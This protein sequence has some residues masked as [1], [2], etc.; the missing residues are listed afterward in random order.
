MQRSTTRYNAPSRV[1]RL[2]KPCHS[3]SAAEGP[4]PTSVH[5][6]QQIISSAI[7]GDI[8]LEQAAKAVASYAS[9]LQQVADFATLDAFRVDR[10]GFP[11]V[12]LG[13]GKSAEQLA[14][15]L[16]S[17]ATRQRVAIATRV[18]VNQYHLVAQLLPD[19]EYHTIARILMYRSPNF[20]QLPKQ[21]RLPGTVAV[22]TAGTADIAV[23][24]ECRLIAENMGCY[25]FKLHDVGLAGLHRVLSNLEAVRAADVVIVVSG[26]DGALAS[27]IAGLVDSPVISVPTSGGYGA[28]LQGITPLL[29]SLNTEAAGV[30]VVNI[31]NGFGAAMM[32]ARMLGMANRLHTYRCKALRDSPA[33][34]TASSVSA[35]PAVPAHET[36]AYT[37]S[38]TTSNIVGS[39]PGSFSTG[40]S[41]ARVALLGYQV[42][43]MAGLE[44]GAGNGQR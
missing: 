19:V 33:V 28:S 9:G 11:E 41:D 16:Q 22:V 14:Q 18:D 32:A 1:G 10:L 15:V 6:A 29:A 27:V 24:E 12:V 8:T 3:S 20:H 5:F 26:M 21:Q 34:Q 43:V 25:V 44:S 2:V 35:P 17:L 36:A 37:T 13:P 30:A 7:R 40:V 23:A 4:N 39:V 42:P 38:Y 31:D